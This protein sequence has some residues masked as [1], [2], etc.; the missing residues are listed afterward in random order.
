MASLTEQD[1][2][3]IDSILE[4]LESLTYQDPQD[5]AVV[6]KLWAVHQRHIRAYA[7]AGM[8][9]TDRILQALMFFPYR[10]R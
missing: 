1:D 3:Q 2:A 9:K 5:F 4:T 7:D 8:P 10:F 6:V